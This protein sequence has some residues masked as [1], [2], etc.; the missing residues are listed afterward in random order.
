MSTIQLLSDRLLV[1]PDYV[2]PKLPSGI[3]VPKIAQ[4]HKR[5]GLVTHVGPGTK[6]NAMYLKQGDVVYYQHTNDV[7]PAQQYKQIEIEGEVHYILHTHHVLAYERDGE[8]KPPLNKTIIREISLPTKSKVGIH[9]PLEDWKENRHA[10]V[11]V[12]DPE[13]TALKAGDKVLIARF[14]STQLETESDSLHIMLTDAIPMRYDGGD[15]YEQGSLDVTMLKDYMLV[16]EHSHKATTDGGI[17]IP[18][19]A[20]RLTY[21]GTVAAA[22][23][24]VKRHY[25]VGASVAFDRLRGYPVTIA[26]KEYKVLRLG[27]IFGELITPLT[28]TR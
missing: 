24:K 28:T 14:V 8:L 6:D 18:D 19:T 20:E 3:Y 2:P 17:I 21:T 25:P 26:G 12:P 7:D 27:H 4:R 22:S 5:R 13:D 10:E 1:K 15:V 9:L 23:S 11:I 16:K